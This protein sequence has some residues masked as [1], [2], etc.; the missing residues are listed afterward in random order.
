[1][2]SGLAATTTIKR[3]ASVSLLFFRR[4]FFSCLSASRSAATRPVGRR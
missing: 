2:Y 1:M 3:L 4:G